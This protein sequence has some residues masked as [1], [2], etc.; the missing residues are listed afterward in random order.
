[1]TKPDLSAPLSTEELDRLDQFLLDRIDDDTDTEDLD[2]G[3]LD[4]STL[5]GFLT[6]IVIGPVM[7]PPSRW[8]PAVWGDFEPVWDS[9][10]DF[11][12]IFSLMMR[13][14]N[15]IASILA[16]SAGHFEPLFLERTVEGKTYTIVDEWCD[17]FRRGLALEKSRWNL[18]DVKLGELLLP[19][20]SFTDVM[21]YAAHDLDAEGIETIRN[22]IAP[23]VRDIHS[24]WL[25]RRQD[26]GAGTS[27]VI[28]GGDKVGRNDP[29]PCGSGKKYKRCC[30]H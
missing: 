23:R 27:P 17:G 29:C 14:M 12:E 22:M 3:I 16:R 13:Q 25:A 30:L 7:I 15:W 2:E 18:K 20:M 19:I 28:R 11:M 9:E 6:A 26:A 24:Y 4:V 21:D 10:K 5:D 1:M 8:L